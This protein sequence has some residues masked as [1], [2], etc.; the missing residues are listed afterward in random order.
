MFP[1]LTADQ[2]ARVV[3]EIVAF[4]SKI[5]FANT[6]EGEEQLLSSDPQSKA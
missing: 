4:T 5:R 6:S 3:E 1:Q 2:Q